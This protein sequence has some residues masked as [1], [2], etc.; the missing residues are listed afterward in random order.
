MHLVSS[1]LLCYTWIH[2]EYIFLDGNLSV[3]F[4]SDLS[5]SKRKTLFIVLFFF[6]LLVCVFIK[7]QLLLVN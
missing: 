1:S 4:L 6:D 7:F 2:P 3:V 5:I